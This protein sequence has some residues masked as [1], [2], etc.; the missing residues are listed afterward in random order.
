MVAA[1]LRRTDQPAVAD[2]LVNAVLGGATS[3]EI[4]G[5]VG[6]VL[7]DHRKLRSRLSDSARSAWD[8]V[9]G[10]VNRAFPGSAVTYW[11]ARLKDRLGIKPNI[12]L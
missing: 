2:L 5:G 10:D 6:V 12:R 9:M 1:E 4:L 11:I 8:A 3:S 7:R